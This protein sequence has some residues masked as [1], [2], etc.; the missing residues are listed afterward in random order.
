VSARANRWVIAA[1]IA[2]LIAGV[3]L[4]HLIEP[5]VKVEAV[6]LA[7][8]TP[9]IR[10]FPA[11]PGAHPVALL[12]HGATGSKETLFR[13]GEALAAAGFNCF[14][15]DFPGHGGSP[16]VFSDRDILLK[17]AEVARA[18]GPVA[19]FV[20]HSMGAG[21]GAWSVREAG[22]G[23]RLFVA[24]G[25]NPDLGKQGPPLLLLAGQFEEFVRPA[26]LKARTDAR[27]VLS[28]WSDH[29]LEL[30]DPCLVNAAV[31]AACAA[32]GQTP[33]AARTRWLWRLAGLA[34]GMA[35][36]VALIYCLPGLPA[37]IAPARGFLVAAVII[38]AQALVLGT[39][40]GWAPYLHRIPLQGAIMVVLWLA[41]V[42]VNKLHLPRWSLAAFAAALA[43]G[44]IIIAVYLMANARLAGV[45][46]TFRL[47]SILMVGT[48]V[49]M[50]AGT[51]LGWIAARGG[52]RRDGDLALAIWVGYAVGQWIPRF[53]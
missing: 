14:V 45:A 52:S 5:G 15:M 30:I 49:A 31:E 10:L 21:A 22:F 7:G 40:F 1:A 11:V 41:L 12:A 48:T 2:S 46:F 17:P 24:V 44:C 43:L 37:Q 33:P 19:V 35:G 18:L 32:V 42:G 27:L 36:A 13:Y 53:F 25:A 47:L 9:A 50:F 16:R 51:I 8:D 29:A 3:A 34:L 23:P 39:W 20:G 6:T 4:S 28:P 26:G 38:L